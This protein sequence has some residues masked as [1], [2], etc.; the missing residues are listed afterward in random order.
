MK[1]M[2]YTLRLKMGQHLLEHDKR[3]H[4]VYSLILTLFFGWLLGLT[5]GISIALLIGLAKEVWDHYR[6]SGFCWIDMIAN[7]LGILLAALCL[8]LW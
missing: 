2:I 7:I 5:A 4:L 3:Q 1:S 8:S 6:G